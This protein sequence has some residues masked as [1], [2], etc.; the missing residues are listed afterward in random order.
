MLFAMCV[1]HV[2]P[3]SLPIHGNQHSERSK[4]YKNQKLGKTAG[5]VSKYG[6]FPGPYFPV[7]RPEETPYFGT[8]HTVN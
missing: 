7:L 6:V 1:T 8:S 5:K 4:N 2:T 3:C